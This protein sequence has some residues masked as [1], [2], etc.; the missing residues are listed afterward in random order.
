[1]AI[2]VFRRVRD[3]STVGMGGFAGLFLRGNPFLAIEGVVRFSRA[4]DEDSTVRVTERLGKSRSPLTVDELLEALDDPRFNVRFEAIISIA[5]MAPDERLI[6]ALAEVLAAP[7]P[8]LSTVAAWALARMGSPRA[9]EPLRTAMNSKYRS[10]QAHAIRSLGVLGDRLIVPQL[11]ER[12]EYETDVGLQLAYSSALGRLQ[13]EEAT[14]RMLDLLR[15]APSRSSRLEMMLDV[16]RLVGHEHHFIHFVRS[17]RREPGTALAQTL[18]TVRRRAEK[19]EAVAP[20]VLKA[21]ESCVG[22]LAREDL[23][24]GLVELDELLGKLPL[25]WMGETQ[26]LI[27]RECGA[28]IA[29]FGA[30]RIEYPILAVHTLQVS[31]HP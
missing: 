26:R 13:I 30:S 14:S 25:G 18:E 20:D 10:V 16:A 17:V 4:G 1:V 27:L 19:S 28:R 2:F 31:W 6:D 11:L 5:R 8:A 7:E 12:L 23:D 24:H 22:T 29:E 21:I 9:I 3:D 15:R